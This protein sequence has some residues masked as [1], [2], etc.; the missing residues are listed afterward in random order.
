MA[1]NKKNS[2]KVFYDRATDALFIAVRAGREAIFDEIA[3]GIGVEK[4]AM[5][6]ILGFEILNASKHFKRTLP[7]MIRTASATLA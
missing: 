2:V 3:P 6:E 1:T 4:N 5:G 7:Q